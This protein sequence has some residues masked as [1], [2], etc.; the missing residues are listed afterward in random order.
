MPEGAIIGS[1][2]VS[3]LGVDRLSSELQQDIDALVGEGLS[4]ERVGQLAARIEAE[5]PEFIVAVRSVQRPDGAVRVIFL[6]A[7]IID[8]PDLASNINARYTVDSVKISG[9]AVMR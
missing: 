3:G 4:H 1:A 9:I 6:V 7:R 2:E 5:L 8:N